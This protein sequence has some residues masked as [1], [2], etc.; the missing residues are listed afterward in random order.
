VFFDVT[1]SIF[2]AS[3]CWLKVL[4]YKTPT[5]LCDC[6]PRMFI[7]YGFLLSQSVPQEEEG[8]HGARRA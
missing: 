5:A 7:C 6:L 8:R 3:S 2:S 4:L 1:Y